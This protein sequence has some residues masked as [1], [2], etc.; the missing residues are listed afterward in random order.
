M[1]LT[2][3]IAY[4]LLFEKL[5]I[6]DKM[7]GKS[8]LIINGAGGVGSVATQMAK[9]AGLTVIATA[10]N[11]RAIDWGT[12]FGADFTVNH[13]KDLFEQVRG[14]GF[15]FV[16][17][18]L[19]LNTVVLQHVAASYELIAPQGCIANIVEPEE[20]INLDKLAHQS[21]SFSFEWM[22]TKSAFMTVDLQSQH[23]ILTKVSQWLDS[24]AL[25]TTLTENLGA[26]STDNIRKV[27][28]MIEQGRTIGK[29]ILC[30]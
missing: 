24:G 15:E 7:N 13:H 29:I 19:I 4:E 21:A 27:H 10:L 28:E 17:N 14:L 5:E 23:E 8:I 9:N 20:A 11:Q 16:D 12:H 3:L 6:T 2:S 26:V 18:I 1:P 25:K 30:Q 22:F